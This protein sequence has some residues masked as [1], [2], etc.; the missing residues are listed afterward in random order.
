MAESGTLQSLDS[1]IN[2][3]RP[4]LAAL[5]L[6]GQVEADKFVEGTDCQIARP[7][8]PMRA[9]PYPEAEIVNEALLGDLVTVYENRDG[10][11]WCQRRRDGYV[12][13][14][15]TNTLSGEITPTTHR[16][17][18]LG[19]FLYRTPEIKSGAL[20]HLSLN[21]LLSIVG[22]HGTMSEVRQGGFVVT[23]HLR[24]Q[25]SYSL[26][27][28][29][30]AER[31]IGVP[32]LWGGRSRIGIDCSGLVQVSM[33][34]AGLD[35]PRDSDMQ[36]EIPGDNVRF[37]DDLSDLQRGDLVFWPGHVGIMSDGMMLVHANA[38]HMAVVT[39]PLITAVHRIEKAGD[40]LAL[41][42]RP[43]QI[44]RSSR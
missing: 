28:I 10:W 5:H 15:H 14:V 31:M 7:I 2:A 27:F 8:V 36:R 37:S 32:Y 44:S 4:D 35:C 21:S 11:A 39:E 24:Q 13:Y 30:V 41:I 25:D 22:T 33:E 18:A 26:D 43:A 40:K 17:S 16:V 34:A 6:R 12:G 9:H 3:Y 23:R 20:M 19:T 38:H 29:D 1:R 42:R